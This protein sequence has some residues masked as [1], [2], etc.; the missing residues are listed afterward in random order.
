[1][2]VWPEAMC[3]SLGLVEGAVWGPDGRPP[4]GLRGMNER[5]I[6]RKS[7]V[8]LTQEEGWIAAPAKAIAVL[9]LPVKKEEGGREGQVF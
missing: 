6:Q 9:S 1:M 8:L 5:V 7:R 4:A 2:G 3:W